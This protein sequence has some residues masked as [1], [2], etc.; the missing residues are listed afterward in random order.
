MRKLFWTLACL[1]ALGGCSHF[2]PGRQ[3][4]CPA[5]G[6]PPVATLAPPVV[7][8]PAPPP[9]E[10]QLQGE[11]PVDFYVRLAL[12]RNPEIQARERG[13][14]AFAQRIPQV[15]A[16]PDP[17]LSGIAYPLASNSLQTAAG[18]ITNGLVLSQKFPWFGK[19]RLRGE[20]ADQETKIALTGLAKTQLKVIEAVKLSY[21]DIYFNQQAIAITR[22]SEKLLSKLFV[23]FAESRYRTGKTSQQDVLLAQVELKKTQ[24]QIIALERQ[25]E[26]TQADLAKLLSASPKTEL[27]VASLPDL[28]PLPDEL[29]LLYKAA[30]ASNPELQGKLQTIFRDQRTI[31]LAKLEYYPDVTLG[32]GWNAITANQ[33]VARSI[34][35]GNDSVGLL[36]SI[37]LPVWRD[38]LRAGVLEAEN[39]TAESTRLYKSVRDDT[40]RF[41]RRFTIQART[42]EEEIKLYRKELIPRASQTLEVSFEDY[43]VGKTDALQVINNW[44]QLLRFRIQLVRLETGLGQTMASLE[45]VVGQQLTTAAN[46]NGTAFPR[47][48][49]LPGACLQPPL[50]APARLQAPRNDDHRENAVRQLPPPTPML[51]RRSRKRIFPNHF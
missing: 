44:L 9:V 20:I 12:Q 51:R 24:D 29:D 2:P 15:T 19:L 17:M 3:A 22:E 47:G 30:A 14:A 46:G 13:V 25:L 31:D 34:A 10:A 36:F 35:N 39:R 32:V 21:Y 28:P 27:R 23:P 4:C 11:H 45:R 40:F 50:P 8:E 41:I 1:T 49:A 7:S 38:K 42:L 48:A 33:A 37:N 18:R 6:P 43:R 16:L 5:G 26:V